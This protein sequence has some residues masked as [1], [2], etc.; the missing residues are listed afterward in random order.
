MERRLIL[1]GLAA[2]A[3]SLALAQSTTDSMTK[4]SSPSLSEA[5]KTPAKRTMAVGSLSLAT[6]RIAAPKA[7]AVAL[8]QFVGFEIA[9]QETVASIL[10]AM[11][12]P[13][14]K[15][16]GEVPKPT[17]V[18]LMRNLDAKGRATVEKLNDMKPGTELERAYVKGQIDGHRELLEIQEAYLREPDNLDATNVTKLAKGMIKEHLA[19]LADIEKQIG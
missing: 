16:S 7:K 15:P 1:A 10:N 17:E 8:K 3:A 13:D 5:A 14:T 2:V 19:L 18:D 11:M 9:E 4:S 12:M 6:S